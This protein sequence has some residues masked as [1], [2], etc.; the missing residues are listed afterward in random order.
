MVAVF[1]F[2]NGEG[3]GGVVVF[4]DTGGNFGFVLRGIANLVRVAD[5][6]TLWCV[7]Q[8]LV[9]LAWRHLTVPWP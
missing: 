9:I 1:A 6:A 8:V 5:P 3:G 7:T 2:V 4:G